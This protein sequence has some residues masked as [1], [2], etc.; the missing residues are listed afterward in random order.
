MHYFEEAKG[1]TYFMCRD[2]NNL[3][4]LSNQQNVIT[5]IQNT[6]PKYFSRAHK[7]IV[8]TMVENVMF[9]QISPA[10]FRLI[11]REITEDNSALDT[12][13]QA[14][15][16]LKMQTIMGNLNSSLC[17]DLQIYHARKSKLDEFWE[18]AAAKIEKMTAVDDSRHAKVSTETRDVVVIMTLTI[19]APYLHKKYFQEAEK[20]GL[21]AE[22]MLSLPWFKL[23]FWP[24][25]A[26]THSAINYTG[27]FS[28]KIHDST[29][30]DKKST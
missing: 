12:K 10:Q 14:K 11:F 25:D 26:T 22:E 21:T 7:R 8:R 9:D 4:H 23:Q 20:A 2:P 27:Q 16:N 19:S 29:T 30:Y 15:F 17:R 1:N 3:S 13:Q 24:K 18:I 5:V 6:L 28:I